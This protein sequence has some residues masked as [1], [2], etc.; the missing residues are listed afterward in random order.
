MH[1]ARKRSRKHSTKMCSCSTS[2]KLWLNSTTSWISPT[3]NFGLK[4]LVPLKLCSSLT[5]Y[6]KTSAKWTTPINCAS[7]QQANSRAKRAAWC[8]WW[9]NKP[10]LTTTWKN[11]STNYCQLYSPST[12]EWASTLSLKSAN[13]QL[14]NTNNLY[15]KITCSTLPSCTT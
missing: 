1:W 4:L 15:M 7:S 6:S 11:T 9:C 5:R 8:Q 2:D 14:S 13:S 3:P 12:A 10:T